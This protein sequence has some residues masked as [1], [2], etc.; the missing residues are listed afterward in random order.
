MKAIEPSSFGIWHLAFGIRRTRRGLGLIELLTLVSILMV[1]LALMVGTARHVRSASSTELTRK[2]MLAL[3]DAAGA[4]IARGI[5]PTLPVSAPVAG[6]G[7]EER[8]QRFALQSSV[9]LDAAIAT[10]REAKA[11][12]ARPIANAIAAAAAGRPELDDA[13]GRPIALIP[14][15]EPQLGMAPDDGPFL[16]SAG[17]DGRFLTLSDNIYSYDLP[18]LIP[19]ARA[20]A[21]VM[22]APQGN[23]EPAAQP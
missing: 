10:R 15:Q 21:D 8:F 22:P 19:A 16:V 5:D 13:W 11:D 9:R 23:D 7:Q 4:A 6:G 20:A 18:V 1:A 2:R 17:P 14:R 3:A 12:S